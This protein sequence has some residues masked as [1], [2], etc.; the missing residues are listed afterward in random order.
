MI[1]LKN[2]I[3]FHES[4]EYILHQKELHE[5]ED[6]IH[7]SIIQYSQINPPDIG[8]GYTLDDNARA[9][10]AM[11]T[12]FKLTGDEKSVYSIRKYLRFIKRCLQPSGDFINYIDK[13]NKF[14][15]Q[16]KASNLDNANGRAVWALGYIVSFMGLLP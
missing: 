13:D 14:T 10:I 8:S 3:I 5:L 4:D 15:G 1:A 12:Y 7:S 2:D 6:R 9:L 11:C 16:N